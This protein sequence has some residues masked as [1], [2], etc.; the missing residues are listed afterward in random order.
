MRTTQKDI[1]RD[2]S[3]SLITVSRA[4]N[5]T[6]YVSQELKNII[7]AYAK[8]H[9]YVPHK[10]SQALVRNKIRTIA[11]FSSSLPAYFWNDIRKGVEIA[12]EQILPFNYVVNYHMVPELD[13]DA[14]IDL[15]TRQV[16]AGLDAVGIVNQRK[17]DMGR[18]LD[19]IKKT[20][21]P[22][23]MFNADAPESGRFRY[24]G[25]DYA[26]GGSLAADFI[27]TALLLSPRRNVLVINV[28]EQGLVYAEDPDI[29][30]ERLFG[31]ASTLKFRYPQVSY[32]VV[33]F[34][35]QLTEHYDDTQIEDLLR[36][37]QGSVDA[38]YLIPAFNTV[39]LEALERL[40]YTNTIT[41]L[42]D[43]D[44]TIS[45]YLDHG[46]LTAAIY[47][48]PV[49][50]GYY[51]VKTLEQLLEAKQPEI[52]PDIEIVHNLILAENRELLRTHNVPEFITD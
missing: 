38:V 24:I 19:I 18:I 40:N 41:V 32:K 47:Q 50:Q 11:L 22:F 10:A 45:R 46:I 27:G 2:L 52:L 23:V 14:Y 13:T 43:I 17:Y 12:A 48:N 37:H 9:N 29:N 42:H 39:F 20:K 33:S 6:G 8:E 49:L 36:I 25:S 4:L 15:I 51:T 34:T 26:D 30:A 21:V 3:I 28:N 16:E 5:N 7:L 1:A 31:F 44:T 35:T